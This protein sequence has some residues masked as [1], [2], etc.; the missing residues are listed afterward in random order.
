MKRVFTTVI[1]A[2]IAHALLFIVLRKTFSAVS[3]VVDLLLIA[4]VA[5]VSL[6]FLPERKKVTRVGH[7]LLLST[8]LAISSVLIATHF[9]GDG[10]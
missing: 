10:L 9:F 2:V 7:V 8:G 5:I 1:F 4:F 6:L 3:E